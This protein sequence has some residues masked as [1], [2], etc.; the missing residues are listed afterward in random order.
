MGGKEIV[1][2]E[3]AVFLEPVQHFRRQ[4]PPAVGLIQGGDHGVA[5]SVDVLHRDS[6][7]FDM[8]N[9]FDLAVAVRRQADLDTVCVPMNIEVDNLSG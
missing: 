4:T 5:T 1:A 8:P 2:K 9:C 6:D 7:I 3:A